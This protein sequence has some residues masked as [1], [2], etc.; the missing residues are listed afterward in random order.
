VRERGVGTGGCCW[1]SCVWFCD[2]CGCC[3]SGSSSISTHDWVLSA[4][5]VVML[6]LCLG[7]LVGLVG[8]LVMVTESVGGVVGAVDLSGD[9]SPLS[10]EEGG[11][12]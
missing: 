11:G 10:V 4:V 5:S 8:A 6:T 9:D 1:L 3:W 2:P 7:G 12:R